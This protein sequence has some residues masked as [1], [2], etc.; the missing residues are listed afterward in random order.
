MRLGEDFRRRML[1]SLMVVKESF[2]AIAER[3]SRQIEYTRL[4]FKARDCTRRTESLFDRIG[5][6]LFDVHAEQSPLSDILAHP[7]YLSGVSEYK[8]LEFE[9]KTIEQKHYT[10]KEED[11]VLHWTDFVNAFHKSGMTIESLLLPSSLKPVPFTLKDLSLPQ[12]ILVIAIQRKQE[13]IQPHEAVTLKRGDRLFLLGAPSLMGPVL[14]RF[15]A[16]SKP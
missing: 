9:L 15:A 4:S 5:R 11:L 2:L 8:Q 13:F 16:P 1:I 12:G 6:F 3:I 14:E 10:L 7:T